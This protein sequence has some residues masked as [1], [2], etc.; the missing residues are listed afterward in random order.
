MPIKCTIHIF[1]EYRLKKVMIIIFPIKFP[2][3]ESM[4]QNDKYH[5]NN[6]FPVIVNYIFSILY[7]VYF[8]VYIISIF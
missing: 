2:E 3:L 7:N 8:L 1:Q 6:M 4:P 5:Y